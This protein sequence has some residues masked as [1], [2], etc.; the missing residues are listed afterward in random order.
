MPAPLKFPLYV[1][2]ADRGRGIGRGLTAAII[3]A[4]R[5]AGLHTLVAR[6]TRDNR[7]SIRLA[8]S[9]GFRQAG[10][11]AEAGYKFGRFLDVVILQLIYPAAAPDAA[12]PG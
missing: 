2:E 9:F 1:R 4:G 7:V 10:V 3:E 5:A 12:R 8:E 6:I 11:L